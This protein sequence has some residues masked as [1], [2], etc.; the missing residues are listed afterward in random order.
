MH[1]PKIT[2]FRQTL[3]RIYHDFKYLFRFTILLN[4]ISHIPD[5]PPRIPISGRSLL[6]FV[7]LRFAKCQNRYLF[8][9]HSKFT[10]IRMLLPYLAGP[11]VSRIRYY[12]SI[13]HSRITRIATCRRD[14]SRIPS[15]LRC[16]L[17]E[18]ATVSCSP[19]VRQCYFPKS[20]VF[21][22]VRGA[23]CSRPELPAPS[24]SAGAAA[25]AGGSARSDGSAPERLPATG[26]PLSP[27]A[28]CGSVVGGTC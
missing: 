10:H 11:V 3:T 14:Q 2:T 7:N 9:I 13:F 21:L 19:T 12:S 22:K 17:A 16:R 5:R 4:P 23:T 26:E 15:D 18:S 20:P 8:R 25:L 27:C 1:R 24:A 28:S 6:R